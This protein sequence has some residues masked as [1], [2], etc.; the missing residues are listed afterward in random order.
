MKFIGIDTVAFIDATG[1]G[2]DQT[3]VFA[4]AQEA[5]KAHCIKIAQI[6]DKQTAAE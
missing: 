1:L 5:V 4:R 3:F 2:N 6:W